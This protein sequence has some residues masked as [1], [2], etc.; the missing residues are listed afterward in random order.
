MFQSADEPAPAPAPVFPTACVQ[1][2]EEMLGLVQRL[3]ADTTLLQL[4]LDSNDQL[5]LLRYHCS[6]AIFSVPLGWV[7]GAGSVCTPPAQAHPLLARLRQLL[8]VNESSMGAQVDGR[9]FWERRRELNEQ[10]KVSNFK[11]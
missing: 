1:G 9:T 6:H 5:W 4:A 10:L 2:S 3:P 7:P 8:A 11:F